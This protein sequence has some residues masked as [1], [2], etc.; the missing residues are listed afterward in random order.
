MTDS[1]RDNNFTKSQI[2]G[3][4]MCV[5]AT[6][7]KFTFIKGWNLDSKF[8]NFKTFLYID[9]M[10][11]WFEVANYLD[12]QINPFYLN[13][14]KNHED[15]RGSSLGSH[16]LM[17][18]MTSVWDITDESRKIVSDLSYDTN[19]QIHKLLNSFYKQLPE[20][21][22]IFYQTESGIKFGLKDLVSLS[23]DEYIQYK[24]LSNE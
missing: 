9:L 4:D 1:L 3:V 21:L 24:P 15:F 12:L 16:M 5:K 6:A 13:Y 14:Y 22:Q 23:V 10:V 19:R 20:E 7:K 2:K 18:G 17:K 11:D 8:E